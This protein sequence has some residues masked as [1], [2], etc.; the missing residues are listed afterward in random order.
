[1]ILSILTNLP[2]PCCRFPA[3]E[4]VSGAAKIPTI[5][6]YDRAGN[7]KAVGAEAV[8]EGIRETAEDEHWVKA[9][10]YVSILYLAARFHTRP[11]SN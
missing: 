2:P 6:Y 11:G 10:W 1:M 8:R 9:E 7:V 5:I 3:H 4:Y